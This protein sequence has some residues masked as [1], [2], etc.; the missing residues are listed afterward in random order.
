MR[1]YLLSLFVVLAVGCYAQGFQRP[2][3]ETIQSEL[4]ELTNT[5]TPQDYVTAKPHVATCMKWLQSHDPATQ[6]NAELQQ[7]KKIYQFILSW[8]IGTN[9]CSMQLE[10]AFMNYNT[11]DLM[12]YYLGGWATH[13]IETN[14]TDGING[15]I[16]GIEA[17]IECY[18]N[19][20]KALKNDKKKILTFKKMQEEGTLR[21]YVVD[22]IGK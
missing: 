10:K 4:P 13:F 11:T 17:I 1:K 15:R 8:C 6:N 16:A 19:Y 20:P 9:E 2:D 5:S 7:R 22:Q 3:Y 18:N 14:D 12:M 21:Q